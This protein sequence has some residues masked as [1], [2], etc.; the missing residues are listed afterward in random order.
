MQINQNILFLELARYS[1]KLFC[2]IRSTDWL[3]DASDYRY[4]ID[5]VAIKFK[6][7]NIS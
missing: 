5:V 7:E 2:N 4:I 1:Y 3:V 6:T